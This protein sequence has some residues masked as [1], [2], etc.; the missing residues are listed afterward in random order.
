MFCSC[1]KKQFADDPV[2]PKKHVSNETIEIII[3]FSDSGEH[4]LVGRIEGEYLA[5]KVRGKTMNIRTTG[6]EGKIGNIDVCI[7]SN[8]LTEVSCKILGSKLDGPKFEH[9]TK[10]SGCKGWEYCFDSEYYKHY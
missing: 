10:A 5:Y 7:M 8:V 9:M 2:K 3:T 4:K 6:N 1:S